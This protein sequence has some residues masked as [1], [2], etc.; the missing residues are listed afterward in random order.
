MLRS[1]ASNGH[2]DTVIYLVGR[3]GF[4]EHHDALV[5]TYRGLHVLLESCEKGM[6]DAGFASVMEAWKHTAGEEEAF[7][8][9][10]RMACELACERNYM[11][12]VIKLLEC[13]TKAQI[14]AGDMKLKLRMLA[15]AIQNEHTE[16]ALS[17]LKMAGKEEMDPEQTAVEDGKLNMLAG[18]GCLPTPFS[19]YTLLL[20]RYCHITDSDLAP[21]IGLQVATALAGV[22]SHRLAAVQFLCNSNPAFISTLDPSDLKD[23]LWSASKL[24]HYETAKYIKETCGIQVDWMDTSSHSNLTDFSTTNLLTVNAS[25]SIPPALAMALFETLGGTWCVGP[26]G[27]A[28]AKV[29]SKDIGALLV[30]AEASRDTSLMGKLRVSDYDSAS[31]QIS[32]DAS[33]LTAMHPRMIVNPEDK[34][35]TKFL[36]G[37]LD[38]EDKKTGVFSWMEPVR[39]DEDKVGVNEDGEESDTNPVTVWR[40]LGLKEEDENEELSFF[41]GLGGR[42][43]ETAQ[44]GE[45]ILREKELARQYAAE[46]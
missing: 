6:L 36:D 1:A 16:M 30:A 11:E 40:D 38:A 26:P 29:T 20:K 10:W 2:R 37:K 12:L 13:R 32:R 45:Q 17:L 28:T 9:R 23:D 18:I 33:F 42:L 7:P 34:M 31:R 5:A 41:L 46:Y 4:N 35:W 44:T 21:Q 25:D 22:R 14:N 24:G 27:D 39:K 15:L 19:R 8:M 3:G 43:P